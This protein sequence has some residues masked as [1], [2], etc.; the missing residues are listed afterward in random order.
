MAVLTVLTIYTYTYGITRKRLSGM[1]M[2]NICLQ[3]EIDKKMDNIRLGVDMECQTV[4][5]F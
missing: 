1:G 3:N 4:M 5:D 2:I